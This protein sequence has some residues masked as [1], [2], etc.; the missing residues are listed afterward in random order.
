MASH[1]HAEQ[2][3]A[4]SG[5][6]ERQPQLLVC[7]NVPMLEAVRQRSV[8]QSDNW[9]INQSARSRGNARTA[10]LRRFKC[11]M[12]ALSRTCQPL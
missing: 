12:E 9:T 11:R 5:R 7:Y 4:P 3:R 2:R 6:N 8:N 1:E 10:W